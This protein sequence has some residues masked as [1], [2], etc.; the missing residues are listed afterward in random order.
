MADT[1]TKRVLAIGCHPDD[2]EFM[3]CGTLLMLQKA[4]WEVHYMTAANGSLG[5]NCM[6]RE[7]IV[8]KRRQECIDA[9]KLAGFHYHESV[10]DDLEVFYNYELLCKVTEVVRAVD[11]SIVLTHGPYDYMEDHV[12]TGRLAVSAAFCRGMTNLRCRPDHPAT[13]REVAVY[14]SMPHSLTDGL[15]RPVIP[16]LYVNISSTLKMKQDMLRCHA[17]Q[18]EWLD[19][20]QGNDAYIEELNFRGKYYGEM[21]KKYELAEGWI[22]HS[23][24]GFSAEDFNP[25]IDALPND[26]FMVEK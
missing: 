20:S 12:N 4:G 17:S 16:E 1:E 14:H 15:R 10:A 7:Q 5:T 8:A 21:S 24:L 6:S 11:P 23:H 22:R 13:L 2:I 19:I 26:S 9:C 18:K 3:M 25:I